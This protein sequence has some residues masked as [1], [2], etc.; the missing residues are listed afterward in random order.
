MKSLLRDKECYV[1]TLTEY[2]YIKYLNT[3]LLKM[4]PNAHQSNP[5]VGIDN[6]SVDKAVRP[7]NKF[8]HV[9]VDEKQQNRLS[10]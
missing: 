4:T 5:I 1:K 6:T 2:T 3:M 8:S 10:L 7:D 9:V